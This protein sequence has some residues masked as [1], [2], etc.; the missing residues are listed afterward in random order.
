MLAAPGIP[1]AR[2]LLRTV[3]MLQVPGFGIW[4]Q[5]GTVAEVTLTLPLA[6]PFQYCAVWSAR[7]CR[8]DWVAESGVDQYTGTNRRVCCPL[9]NPPA[10][11]PA[12]LAAAV[13]AGAVPVWLT[14]WTTALPSPREA[15]VTAAAAVMVCVVRRVTVTVEPPA[16]VDP[17]GAGTAR[18]AT[19]SWVTKVSG[20]FGTIESTT[21]LSATP[22]TVMVCP[23]AA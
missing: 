2:G 16:T 3:V 14:D 4:I 10:A 18:P 19:C 9:A 8:L 7:D 21:I 13:P 22:V 5:F 1:A 12:T 11:V 15:A 23:V 17:A 20:A 6:C